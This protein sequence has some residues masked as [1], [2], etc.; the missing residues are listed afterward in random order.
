MP[1]EGGIPEILNGQFWRLFTPIF[2]HYG[3]MHIVFNMMWLRDLGSMIEGRESTWR[4]LFLVLVTA[5]ISNLAQYLIKIPSF[6]NLSGGQPN[7]GGMSG[8]VYG[9]L[10]YIWIRGKMH[11]ASGLLLHKSTVIMMLVWLVLCFTGYMGP[12][13]NMAHLF[14]LLTGMALGFLFSLPALRQS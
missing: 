13:A 11:R 7:F 14:G 10:G 2:I 3:I 5:A 4:L 12:I 8:V 6:P 1:G 9:L